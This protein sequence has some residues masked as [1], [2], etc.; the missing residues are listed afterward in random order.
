MGEKEAEARDHRVRAVDAVRSP[1]RSAVTNRELPGQLK[2]LLRPW[3]DL[4]EVGLDGLTL[5]LQSVTPLLPR[6][7]NHS[8]N[9][10]PSPIEDRLTRLARALAACASD[11]SRAHFQASEYFRENQILARRVKA[12][13]ATLRT[14]KRADPSAEDAPLDPD[15][16]RAAE[17]YLP[18]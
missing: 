9:E 12:L 8:S 13:E 18:P 4:D 16:D 7:G 2:E 3:L 15:A 1:G 6:P 11:R 10:S 5:F 17:R 14:R